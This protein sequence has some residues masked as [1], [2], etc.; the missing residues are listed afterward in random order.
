MARLVYLVLALAVIGLVW[1]VA[2]HLAALVGITGP[3]KASLGFMGPALFVVAVPTIFVLNKVTEDFKQKDFWRAAL[4]GCPRW[5][6]RAVWATFGY[7]WLGFFFYS[8]VLGGGEL[9]TVRG[10]SSVLMA[11]YAV[12][13]AALFSATRVREHDRTRRCANGHAVSPLAKFCEECG[14]HVPSGNEGVSSI[15]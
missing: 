6:Q 11:F 8:L 12:L 1:A 2:V 7:A 15:Q 5:M 3:F 4:R 9:S 10:M 14:A 13:A